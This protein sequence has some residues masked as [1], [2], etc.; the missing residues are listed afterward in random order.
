MTGREENDSKIEWKINMM[1]SDMPTYVEEWYM[2]LRANKM[3]MQTCY[4]YLTKIRH[5]LRFINVFPRLVAPSDFTIL[6]IEKYMINIQHREGDGGETSVAYQSSV[7]IRLNNFME[8]LFSRDYI[9]YNPIT[10]GNIN[11]PKGTDSIKRI[12]LTKEDFKKIL[13]YTIEDKD[14][15]YIKCRDYAILLLFMTT[16]MRRTALASINIEDVDLEE[17]TIQIIDKGNKH[18]SYILTPQTQEAIENWLDVRFM[19]DQGKNDNALF[20][21]SF[22][23]RISTSEI[24]HIVSTATENTLGFKLSPHKLRAGFITIMCEETGDIL[25]VQEA[26]GHSSVRTTQRYYAQNGRGKRMAAK[27][28]DSI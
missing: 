20:L 6:T 21:S 12:H 15:S 13:N 10:K 3:T 24:Y 25:A 5:F 26:V 8:F 14:Q 4:E 2:H 19:C 28:F 7:W 1:L 22:G 9:P 27:I 11:K 17:G 23:N 16:G 18:H